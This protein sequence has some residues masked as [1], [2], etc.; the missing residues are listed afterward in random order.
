MPGRYMVI[1][2]RVVYWV[3]VMASSSE[4]VL[5]AAVAGIPEIAQRIAFIPA[6]NRAAAFDAVE[7]SYLR[8][9]KNLGGTEDLAQKWTSA[10]MFRLCEEVEE[11]VLANRRLL[12]ALHD[13]L[14]GKPVEAGNSD[15]NTRVE[16][17]IS[18]LV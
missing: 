18:E 15:S 10:V 1:I 16:V 12:K 14:V 6:A 11:R 3:G 4:E 7:R 13:E 8:T 5:E 9:A 17:E 2:V